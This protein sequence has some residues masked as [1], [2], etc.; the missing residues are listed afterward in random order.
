MFPADKQV[1]PKYLGKE[2][3]WREVKLCNYCGR[4]ILPDGRR[5]ARKEREVTDGEPE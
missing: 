2:N 3:L 1:C 5:K 4:N